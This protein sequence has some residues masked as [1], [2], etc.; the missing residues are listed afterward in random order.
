MTH[1]LAQARWEKE[2][3]ELEELAR[4]ANGKLS[5]ETKPDG[6]RLQ[7]SCRSPVARAGREPLIG[8]CEHVID[9]LRP[10]AWPVERL[11]VFHR[12]PVDILHPNVF[13]PT[14][15]DTPDSVPEWWQRLGRGVVCYTD[16]PAPQLRLADIVEQLYDMLGYRFGRYSRELRDCLSPPAVRWVNRV[17]AE[18]PE[19]IPTEQRALVERGRGEDGNR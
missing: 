2:L 7:L 6:L 10:D 9:I 4:R 13:Y 3:G 15:D 5:F 11:L 12:R 19:L 16:R 8:V 18:T 17:L 1:K 14:E